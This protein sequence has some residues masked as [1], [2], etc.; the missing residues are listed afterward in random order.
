MKFGKE[1]KLKIKN[2]PPVFQK[3][4]ISYK[5]WKKLIK[6]YKKNMETKSLE[7]QIYRTSTIIRLLLKDICIIDNTFKH[8]INIEDSCLLSIFPLLRRKN[9]AIEKF[10]YEFAK[11]NTE[12][13]RKICKKLDK[14]INKYTFMP[15]FI[16][17]KENHRYS[18]L[19]GRDITYL[20]MKYNE[21]INECPICMEDKTEM[22]I[23][24]CGHYMCKN[25][26]CKI[27]IS[28]NLSKT[29]PYCHC[30]SAF[31]NT[32]TISI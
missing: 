3:S 15:W 7:M 9:S 17:C 12:A 22:I 6:E 13:I 24:S 21:K 5:K 2:F 29:C 18:F 23:L 10:A 14:S 32:I 27:D 8:N 30:E 25:C 11:L 20:I 19:G 1:L 31:L 4:F 28:K 16:K 26:V